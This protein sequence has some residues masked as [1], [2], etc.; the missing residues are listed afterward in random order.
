MWLKCLVS[1]NINYTKVANSNKKK[2]LETIPTDGFY[3]FNTNAQAKANW[4]IADWI[5]PIG[6][7]TREEEIELCR[8][9]GFEAQELV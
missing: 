9:A 5:V 3:F 8:V 1:D 4:I 2:C 6:E 7:I